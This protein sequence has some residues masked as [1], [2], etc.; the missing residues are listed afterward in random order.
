VLLRN[1]KELSPWPNLAS[2][3]AAGALIPK[4]FE[5]SGLIIKTIQ[6][7]YPAGI[8]ILLSLGTGSCVWTSHFR[9]TNF[10]FAFYASKG[11]LIG[12]TLREAGDVEISLNFS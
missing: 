4:R 9:D 11:Q 3:G 6:P 8:N 1:H 2:L 10:A 12:K 5:L 7:A